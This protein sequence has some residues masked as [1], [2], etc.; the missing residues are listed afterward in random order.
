MDFAGADPEWCTAPLAFATDAEAARLRSEEPQRLVAGVKV[1]QSGQHG[2]LYDVFG[3]QQFDSALLGVITRRRRLKGRQGNAVSWRGPLLRELSH[4]AAASLK[5]SLL[6]APQRHT[7]VQFGEQF[8]LK[9]YRRLHWGINP[10]LEVGRFLT[11]HSF[12]YSPA[13]AGA[14]EYHRADGERLC[15]ADVHAWV[16]KAESGWQY[17][18]GALD[19]YYERALSLAA[20]GR[21]VSAGA[22]A[23]ASTGATAATRRG[24]GVRRH[25]LGVGAVAGQP[26]CRAA[27]H[28][29]RVDSSNPDFAPEPVTSF[30]QRGLYQ[31]MRNTARQ[32]LPLLRDRL[33]GLA[34]PARSCGTALLQREPDVLNR[35][36]A[37]LGL[38]YRAMRIRC[39]GDYSL[40]E[41]LYTGKDFLIVDFEGH[42]AEPISERRMKRQVLRD[43]AGMLCSFRYASDTALTRQIALGRL[44]SENRDVLL[45]WAAYW[46]VWVSAAF[47]KGYLNDLGPT[48][49]LPEAD[50]TLQALLEIHLLER[51]LEEVG[52]HVV[53]GPAFIA[54]ACE[55]IM[56][57]LDQ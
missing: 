56:Q 8:V 9:L 1:S 43:V 23:T 16:P 55:G 18:L 7:S 33:P 11:E 10:G 14:L 46:R 15:F 40:S 39:H 50:T 20:E 12:P 17:T 51:L 48:P 22:T 38:R 6:K 31:A 53:A 47:L 2:V 4:E 5:G 49:L 3:I 24:P 29:L 27:S 37:L 44:P 41:V 42:P 30:Y 13:L 52:A 36:Q 25:L 26:D 34:E 54:P 45:P 28:A 19:R 35:F 32:S 57:L 21:K